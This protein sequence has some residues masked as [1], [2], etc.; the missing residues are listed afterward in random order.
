MQDFGAEDGIRTRDNLLGRQELWPA[1]L[2]PHIKL[3]SHWSGLRCLSSVSESATLALD[4]HFYKATALPVHSGALM[5][6]GEGF[7]P[8]RRLPDLLP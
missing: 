1:E 3:A 5:A 2:L 7:E 4:Y 8:S 6:E